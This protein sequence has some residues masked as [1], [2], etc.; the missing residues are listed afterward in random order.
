MAECW[1][2][3]LKGG[4]TMNARSFSMLL[5]AILYAVVWLGTGAA[6]AG[7]ITGYHKPN[8]TWTLRVITQKELEKI[9]QKDMELSPS[10]SLRILAKLN[11]R[12][13]GTVKYYV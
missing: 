12:D 8:Q 5:F 9:S 2:A 13:F 11:A 3:T 7:D 10:V 4:V 1:S 6:R